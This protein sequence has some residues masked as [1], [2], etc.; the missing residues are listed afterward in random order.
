[1]GEKFRDFMAIVSG[2]TSF[3]ILVMMSFGYFI[4]GGMQGAFGMVDRK[5]AKDLEDEAGVKDV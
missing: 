3:L 1:M 2:A 5:S 4:Y